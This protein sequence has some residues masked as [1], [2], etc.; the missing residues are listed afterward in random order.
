[1]PPTGGGRRVGLG[2]GVCE[3]EGV[4]DSDGGGGFKVLVGVCVSVGPPPALLLVLVG[5][6]EGVGPPPLEVGVGVGV[7]EGVG[8]PV[9]ETPPIL[10]KTAIHKI[11]VRVCVRGRGEGRGAE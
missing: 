6:C 5:V 9:A 2:V 10:Q 11:G 3:E 8:V 1:M 7:F 4:P